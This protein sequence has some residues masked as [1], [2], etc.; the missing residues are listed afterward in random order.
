ME[1]L[2]ALREIIQLTRLDEDLKWSIPCYT[3]EGK[4][5]LTLSALKDKVSIGFFKG[6]LLDDPNKIL[7]P[8]GPNSRSAMQI[9]FTSIEQVTEQT[10]WIKQLVEE[11][12]KV[13]EEGKAV[14]FSNESLDIP[15]ELQNLLSKD[16]GLKESWNN[17]TLGRKRSHILHINSAKQ[18]KTRINRASKCSL[19]IIQGKGFNEY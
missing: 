8:S 1:I 15:K 16:T 13:E 5:V 12:I 4:N 10:L 6:V 18:E 3:F 11:A 17:L 19:K 9:N 7:T 2:T 14:K